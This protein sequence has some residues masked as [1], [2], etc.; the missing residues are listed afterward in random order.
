MNLSDVYGIRVKRKKRHRV[1]RGQ[2]SGWGTTSGRGNK[3]AGQRSGNVI[4]LHFEGGQ[5]PIYRRLPKKGFSNAPF[6]L[7]YHVV[8]VGDLEKVCE[9]G[10]TVDLD[11]LKK[12]GY[13]PKKAKFLK[14]LG[15]GEISKALQIRAHAVSKGA[16]AKIEAASGSIEILPAEREHRPKGVKKARTSETGSPS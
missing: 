15:W 4:R 11:A 16:R 3:G 1:G 7:V 12:V 14:V 2:G 10:A 5:M 8:N 6:K 13:A 9:A